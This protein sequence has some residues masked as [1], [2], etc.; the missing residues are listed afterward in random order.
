MDEAQ[1]N[2]RARLWFAGSIAAVF[3]AGALW[4]ALA[5]SEYDIYQL[6]THDT[7][8]GL[9]A[10]A[11][12]EFHGVEV[13]RVRSVRLGGPRTVS[14]LMEV[15]KG[16]P[17]SRATLAT[18]TSRGLAMRGF[19]GY[20]YV[21]LE[22]AGTDA[23]PLQAAQGS[24]YPVIP[25]APSK[26]VSMDLAMSQVDGNVQSLTRLVQELLDQDTLSALKE[27]AASLER[28]SRTL[29]QNNR[30]VEGLL[31]NGERASRDAVPFMRSASQAMGRVD[32][33]LDP[34]TVASLQQLAASLKRVSG[35]LADNNGKLDKLIDRGEEATRDLAPLVQSTRDTVRLLETQVL[36]EA[37]RALTHLDELSTTLNGVARK[38]N[39]DPS[40]LLRGARAPAPGPGES[41]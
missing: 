1:V 25:A 30:R 38:V 9:I 14:I 41:P 33:L 15:R 20:V 13:G 29:A 26:V 10:D 6:E 5:S 35:M 3:A 2:R 31:V 39:R 4:L 21:S 11:P 23:A 17:V 24:R 28:V 40:V 8:S 19:T 22:D 27:S 32:T 7:V 37:H 18:I 34:A 16:A 12:V 36:P